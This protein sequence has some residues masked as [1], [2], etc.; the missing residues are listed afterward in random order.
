M[1]S[2]EN[3]KPEEGMRGCPEISFQA[4]KRHRPTAIKG[5]ARALAPH[6]S[7]K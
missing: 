5:Y 6:F 4:R 7:S 3:L 2:W 1:K